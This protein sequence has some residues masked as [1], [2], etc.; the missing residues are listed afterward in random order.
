[1]ANLIEATPIAGGSVYGVAQFSYTVGGVSGK[2]YAAALIAATLKEST[3]IEAAASSYS[4]VVQ[5]RARKIDELGRVLAELNK[6]LA[7]LK[8]SGQSSDTATVDNGHWVNTTASKY[9]ITLIFNENTSDMTR[10]NIMKG[11]NEIQYVIDTEDNNMQQDIV[12]L[13]GLLSKRDNAFSSASRIVKKAD[14]AAST[15]IHNIV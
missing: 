5:E 4:A 15:V 11:Q 12:A 13:Q 8:S 7:K 3:A 6:A 10:A 1:M 9:G 2:D 14:D